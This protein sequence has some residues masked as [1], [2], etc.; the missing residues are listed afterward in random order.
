[1]WLEHELGLARGT[2]KATVLIE[3]LPAA[4]EMEEVLYEMREHC[5][6][7]NLGRWDYI[8]SSIK[9]LSG[10]GTRLLPD[11]DQLVMS[12]PFLRAVSR[13]L[14]ATCHRR[15]AQAIG[16]MAAQVPSRGDEQ[17]AEAALRKVEEDKRREVDE[18][19]DGTWVAHPGLVE[20]AQQAW[21]SAPPDQRRRIPEGPPVTEQE[22]LAVPAGTRSEAGLRRDLDVCLRYLAA[23]LQGTGCIPLQ[24]RMEDAATAEISRTLIWQWVRHRARLDDGRI[25]TAEL[26]TRLL[27]EA[28]EGVRAELG[29]ERF[30][31]GSWREAR[32][33]LQ[34]VCLDPGLAEFL[35]LPAYAMLED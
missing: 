17:A 14:V 11:R 5:A 26:V 13:L 29:T 32:D 7:L 34:H 18:G 24:G 10:D 25:V 35:T 3:T 23:W 30:E 16:G 31:A 22:L 9:S 28:L 20:L 12:Q 8:F 4:F 1:V 15:G 27:A 33:L 2:M 6:G 19:Y 21:A